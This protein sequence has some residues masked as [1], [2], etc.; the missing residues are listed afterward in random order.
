[1]E[2]H[3]QRL[4]LGYP[5]DYSLSLSYSTNDHSLR[6]KTHFSHFPIASGDEQIG[7]DAATAQCNC[8]GA[9]EIK[10]DFGFSLL[11]FSSSR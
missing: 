5:L 1:M 4:C 7:I 2:W 6:F 10:L 3:L 8:F 11:G 9:V